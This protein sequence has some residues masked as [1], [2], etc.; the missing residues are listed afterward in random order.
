MDTQSSAIVTAPSPHPASFGSTPVQVALKQ[1]G[2]AADA[3]AADAAGGRALASSP[4]LLVNAVT[5]APT[6]EPTTATI[7]AP[8]KVCGP[9]RP[10]HDRRGAPAV[11]GSCRPTA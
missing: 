1:A 3:G 11:S 2:T 4:S 10:S 8:T 5:K 7:N 6:A 9:W